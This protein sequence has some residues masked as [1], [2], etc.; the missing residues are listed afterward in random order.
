MPELKFMKHQ[1]ILQITSSPDGGPIYAETNLGAIIAEPW[2]AVSSLL[3]LLPALYWFFKLKGKYGS[4]PFIT[5]CIPLLIIGGIGSTLYHAF[6]SSQLLLIMDVLPITILTL[7]VSIFFWTKVFD[8]WWKAIFFVI[9]PVYLLQY[10][11]NHFLSPPTS[12]NISYLLTGLNIFLPLIIIL[13]RTEYEKANLIY[14]AIFF[15]SFGFI[16]RQT[17]AYIANYFAIGSHFL[18]HAFTATG[19]FFIAEYIYFY[20]SYY[21]SVKQEQKK[22]AS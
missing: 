12:I 4:Y 18:W 17:D 16:F 10:L 8:Q 2:N 9:V 14:L 21:I 5:F 20:R 6:R 3:Y 15:F 19:A 22:K 13:S 7:S 11:V 1:I